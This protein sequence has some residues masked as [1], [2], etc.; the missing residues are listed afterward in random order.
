MKIFCFNGIF[1]LLLAML[2]NNEAGVMILRQM[3]NLYV[4]IRGFAFAET[5]LSMYKEPKEMNISKKK[6]LRKEEASTSG[7]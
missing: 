5:S 3:V 4:T 2:Y 1:V 7:K 6:A